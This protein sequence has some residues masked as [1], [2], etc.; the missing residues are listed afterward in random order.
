MYQKTNIT[1]NWSIVS[2]ENPRPIF[3]HEHKQCIFI[4]MAILT[5][6]SILQ[7]STALHEHSKGAAVYLKMNSV[8]TCK[9]TCKKKCENVCI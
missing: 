4:S 3:Y 2:R 7:R 5:G 1:I 8:K 6:K 9:K